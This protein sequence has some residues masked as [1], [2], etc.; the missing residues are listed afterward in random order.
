MRVK[1][2]KLTK[3]GKTVAGNISPSRRDM[4][5][6]YLYDQKNRTATDEEIADASGLDKFRVRSVLRQ[7]ENSGLVAEVSVRDM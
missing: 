7:F 3:K 6:D 5:L 4:V 2:Y 1:V